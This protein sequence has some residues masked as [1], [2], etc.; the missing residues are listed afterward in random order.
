MIL[1]KIEVNKWLHDTYLSY[2]QR[3]TFF[4]MR[5]K[6]KQKNRR[7]INERLT[8]PS[9]LVFFSILDVRVQKN[10][11]EFRFIF[12]LFKLRN[13]DCVFMDQWMPPNWN[14]INTKIVERVFCLVVA[15]D[16]QN[17]LCK[18][19]II[20]FRI[21]MNWKDVELADVNYSLWL[22]SHNQFI[23]IF[24]RCFF[25]RCEECNIRL[26]WIC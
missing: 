14:Y 26:K 17:L 15:T 25:L 18:F 19:R 13:T 11:W 4:F 16:L 12:C 24:F 6:K 7:K 22:L 23:Y 2:R 20:T 5:T 1:P 3:T 9:D 10:K 21:E 8:E